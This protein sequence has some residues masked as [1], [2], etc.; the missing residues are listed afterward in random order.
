MSVQWSTNSYISYTLLS[1]Q[2]TDKMVMQKPSE[3]LDYLHIA[4]PLVN[5][6]CNTNFNIPYIIQY[7]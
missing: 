7:T 6:R 3:R 5:D 4:Q 1:P 2:T